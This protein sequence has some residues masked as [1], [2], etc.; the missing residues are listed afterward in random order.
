[1][2]T[3]D[4]NDMQRYLVEEEAEKWQEGHLTRREFMRRVTLIV[5]GAVAAA[6]VLAALGC[7]P[8]SPAASTP[9][10][11]GSAPTSAPTSTALPAAT[12]GQPTPASTP[13]SGSP[14]HVPEDDPDVRAEMV[15]IPSSDPSVKLTGYM[16]QPAVPGMSAGPLPPAGVL[17]IHENRGLTD[18]IKDVVRRLAKAHYTALCVD[19]VSRSGGSA[20]HPDEAERTGILGQMTPEQV[21]ADLSAGVDYLKSKQSNASP[22][23]GVVGFCFGGGYTFRLATKRPDLKAAAAFYGPN[24]PLEDV[25]NIKAAMLCIYG[26]LDTRITGGA[27]ALE[28]AFKSSSVTYEIKVYEGANHAFHNDT[29]A[30]YDPA[31]AKDAWEKTLAW[32]GKYL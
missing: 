30:R 17:V 18:H 6:P 15:D 23:L 25:S 7:D 31:A 12:A 16:A 1:M 27:P 4:L 24:P 21:L 10:P 26:S 13:A 29:G 9:E 3:H 11:T 28:E 19:L 2:T 14:Y 32:F 20:A 5:G 8:N 22:R